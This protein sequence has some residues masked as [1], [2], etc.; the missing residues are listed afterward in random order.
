M[1]P[2]EIENISPIETGGSR[3]SLICKLRNKFNIML[4][5]YLRLESNATIL[6]IL[7]IGNNDGTNIKVII[8]LMLE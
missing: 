4:A 8:S 1:E 5:L 3:C 6:N 2:R 7:T